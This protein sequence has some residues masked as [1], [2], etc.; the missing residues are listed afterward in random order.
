M[1]SVGAALPIA[2]VAPYEKYTMVRA[3]FA[4]HR[5]VGEPDRQVSRAFCHRERQVGWRLIDAYPR[6]FIEMLVL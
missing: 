1:I 3:S 4:R 2:V 6:H 5:D